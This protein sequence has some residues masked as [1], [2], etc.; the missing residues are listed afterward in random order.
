MQISLSNVA[1]LHCAAHFL[2]MKEEYAEKN[3]EFGTDAF[4]K[5]K[6]LPNASNST[7]LLH[8]CENVL[9][10]AEDIHL[11]LNRIL[12][13]RL[14]NYAYTS[15]QGLVLR[16]PQL[17]LK[18]NYI[19]LELQKMQRVTVEA[20]VGLLPTQSRKSS[21]PMAFLSSLLESAIVSFASTSCGAE[22]DRRIGLQ[23][24]RAI[25][26]DILI[27]LSLNGNSHHS[28]TSDTDDDN[29]Q[30]R[31]ESKMVYDFDSP[32][33]PKQSSIHKVSE[34][35]DNYLADIALDLN[36]T[37]SRF[38]ALAE[39]LPDHARLVTDELYR[40]V[41]I[42]LKSPVSSLCSCVL[43]TD[44]AEFPCF[45]P[46]SDVSSDLMIEGPASFALRKTLNE[47]ETRRDLQTSQKHERF[48]DSFAVSST[49]QEGKR[50]LSWQ[51]SSAMEST[52]RSRPQ[53][54]PCYTAQPIP[55]Y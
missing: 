21:V 55:R 11:V 28:P 27:P 53:M 33:S 35:L 38:I 40:T 48:L 32:N 37:A 42:F 3:L 20:L 10:M 39:L 6:V 22:L 13:A 9:P 47:I 43:D 24:D 19:D 4:I 54:L 31:D 50:N 45:R 2:G 36:L 1:M 41:D 49:F 34:L 26:E 44:S 46:I 5:D 16:D 15:L 8:R 25:L 14:I 12:S 51:Q 18:P 29:N 17:V 30:L 7:S 52:F 23:L